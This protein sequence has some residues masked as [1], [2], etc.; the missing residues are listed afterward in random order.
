MP[1]HCVVRLANLLYMGP[2]YC[3]SPTKVRELLYHTANARKQEVRSQYSPS[4]ACV[5]TLVVTS[6]SAL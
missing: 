1:V 5:A 4:I 6:E 3:N 2:R